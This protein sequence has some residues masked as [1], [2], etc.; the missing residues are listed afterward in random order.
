MRF[1]ER[2]AKRQIHA[3]D[4]ARGQSEVGTGGVIA[5]AW[6]TASS[7]ASTWSNRVARLIFPETRTS[8]PSK[9]HALGVPSR[10]YR[11][12]ATSRKARPA[13]LRTTVPPKVTET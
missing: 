8:A 12:P 5:Q 1:V 4:L 11:T 9:D 3:A 2:P 6:N 7:I 10:G 13:P